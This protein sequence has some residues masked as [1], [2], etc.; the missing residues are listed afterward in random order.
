MK[1]TISLLLTL[2]L[3]LSLCACG[4]G[5]APPDVENGTSISVKGTF[6]LEPSDEL[7][8]SN[9]GLDPVQRYLLC[10]YDVENAGDSNQELS[11]FDDSV[12]ITFNG[13]NAYDQFSPID[14]TALRRFLANCGYPRSTQIDTLWGG[15]EPVRMIAA[16]AINKNDLKD[17]CSAVIDFDLSDN[18]KASVPI[19]GTDIQTI[20][21]FDNIFAVEDDPDAYQIFHSVKIRAD[22]CKA[23]LGKA[24]DADRANNTA[25]RNTYLAICGVMFDEDATWGVSCCSSAGDGGFVSS[26]QLPVFR[27]DIVALYDTDLADKITTVSG[28]IQTIQTQLDS[29]SPDYDAV[30]TANLQAYD[31]LSEIIA[32]FEN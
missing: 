8:L 29:S 21:L 23:A 2:A 10:V 17:D 28:D 3:C 24:S 27:T 9:D 26:E 4:G 11:P 30:N 12:T 32:S 5:S 20:G 25:L 19:A 15:S 14:D 1:R 6:L 18:L 22:I 13:S 31:T 7:D 16:F